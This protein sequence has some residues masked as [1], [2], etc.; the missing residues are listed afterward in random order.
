MRVLCTTA[1][2]VT[3]P[4]SEPVLFLGEWCRRHERRG[5][6]GALDAE[7]LPYH[8]DDRAR[9]Q[10]D[11]RRLAG[12][13]ERL[14]A[15]LASRLNSLHG[16]THSLRY[17]R[18]LVGP[19][20][21][22][23]VQ[24]LFDRWT[25]VQEALARGPLAGSIVLRGAEGTLIPNDMAEFSQLFSTDEWNHLVYADILE[26]C[27]GV[28]LR[29]LSRPAPRPTASVPW[30]RRAV[31]ALKAAATRAQRLWVG[32]RDAFLLA[33]YLPAR[34]EL[35]VHA[36]LG[37]RPQRWRPVAPVRAI[38]DAARRQWMLEGTDGN[39]DDAFEQCARALLARHIP[40]LYLEGYSALREQ[41]REMPW[42]ASTRLIWTSNAHNSDEVFKAW[43]AEKVELGATLVIGQHGGHYGTGAWSFTEDHDLAIC[44]GYLSWGWEGPD[45][46]IRPIGQLKA[47]RLRPGSAAARADALLV[48][49]A[50][51]RYSYWMYSVFVASQWLGYFDDLTEFVGTLPEPL[52]DALLVRLYPN[53]YGWNQYARLREK[54]PRLR[55]DDGVTEMDRLIGSARVYI[56]TYNATGFLEAMTMDIPTVMFWNPRH[57][58]LRA[59]ASQDFAELERVGVFHSTPASAARHLATIW[60]D[61]DAWWRSDSVRSAVG[62]FR[63]RYCRMPEHLADEVVTAL[64]AIHAE[65]L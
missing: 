33:T 43:A 11:Y 18:I 13:H 12:L 21:G 39:S 31:A 20:L 26:R 17:W 25:S 48:T 19:W 64:R 60:H 7:V 24:I 29:P 36:L 65:A 56:S 62:A 8:W 49:C 38:A 54:F 1:L 42:P 16:V 59:S 41:V 52:R 9:L 47:K 53:D 22:Y 58:E 23:F 14:L 34:E 4:D 45:A 10:A 40:T 55:I 32:D 50:L 5:V 63:Q 46:R 2:E 35:S 6:W 3:W 27:K 61:V 28:P 51:P 37:Q 15:D 44:D 30:T 57:W